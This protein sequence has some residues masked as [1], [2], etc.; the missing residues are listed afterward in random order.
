[1]TEN[2]N[3]CLNVLAGGGLMLMES[4]RCG[5]LQCQNAE[6][7]CVNLEPVGSNMFRCPQN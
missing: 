7:R 4:G 3:L 6:G 5:E 1:M 2:R